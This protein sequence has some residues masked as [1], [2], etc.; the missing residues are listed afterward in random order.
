MSWYMG[1]FPKIEI[2]QNVV[3]ETNPLP[4]SQSF[5]I[6]LPETN[7]NQKRLWK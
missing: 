1:K 4:T 7:R 3:W 5:L 2:F 6:P